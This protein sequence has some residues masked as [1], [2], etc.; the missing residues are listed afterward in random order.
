M[1]TFPPADELEF[2]IGAELQQIALDPWSLQFRFADGGS[3]T[4]E[5]RIEHVEESGSIYSHDC[6]KRVGKALYLHQ[7]LQHPITAVS[8]EP[9]CLSL[10]FASGAILRI[11]SE[12]SQ[13]ECGQIF[14]SQQSGRGFIVF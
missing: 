8:A 13:Y 5:G 6:Q 3:I 9:F 14:P 12:L 4:V 11:F 2:L 10:I 7:L 1:H